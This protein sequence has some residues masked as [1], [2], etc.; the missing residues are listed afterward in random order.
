[1]KGKIF[2]GRHSTGNAELW[3]ESK[4]AFFASRDSSEIVKEKIRCWSRNQAKNGMCFIG[5]FHSEAESALFHS[6]LRNG[7]KAIWILGKS[8]PE[9]LS[10]EEARALAEN[11]LLIVSCFR[12]ERYTAATSRFANHIAAMHSDAIVFAHI[13]DR[14]RLFPFYRR[15]CETRKNAV[16]RI[17]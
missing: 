17:K 10:C 16:T 9:E 4:I 14:S 15:I 13:S 7:G 3:S 5:A 1:M 2:N 6:A 8:I 11:R 12:R